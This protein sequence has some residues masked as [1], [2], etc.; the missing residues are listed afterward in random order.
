MHGSATWYHTNNHLNS[1]TIF[2]NTVPVFRRNEWTGSLG[3]P[4]IKNKTFGFFS[5]DI[6]RA[7]VA[8]SST[9][10]DVTPE[11]LNALK[12]LRP[13]AIS[14]GLLTKYPASITPVSNFQT[15]GAL[16][17]PTV[18]CAT[19]AGGPSRTVTTPIG[20][21]PCNMNVI[22]EANFTITPPRKG[23]QYNARLDHVFTAND[24]FF[25]S[26]F[27]NDLSTVGSSVRA[28]FRSPTDQ[29]TENVNLNWTHTFS[30]TL[31]NEAAF[32]VVRAFGDG[33]CLECQIPT[34]SVTNLAGFGNGGPTIFAQNNYEW[35][36]TLTWSRKNHTF[37][38]GLNVYKAQSNFNPTK[39]YQR[40]NFTFNSTTAIFDFA[41]DDPNQ[42]GNIGFNPVDGSP[43][44]PNVAE[45]QQYLTAFVQDNWKVK[46][47]LSV[48]LGLRW[49]EFGRVKEPTGLTNVVFQSGNDFTSR[50]ADGKN[51]LVDHIFNGDW[52][53]FGPRVS[54]AWDPTKTGRMSIRGGAGMF[55]DTA[56]SQL[57]GGSHFNPP[58]WAIATANKTTP[59]F[60]PL[61]GLGKSATDPYQFPRPSNIKTGLDSR[62]GLVSGLVGVT[63]VD[64]N[65][66]NSYVEN[67]F[68]GIQYS[69]AENWVVEGNYVGSG[70][71]KLYA[72]FDV[73]R[74]NGDLLDGVTNRLNPSFGSINYAH[75]PFTSNYE[76]G[77]L[78]L[79]KRFSRGLS[80]EAAYTFGKAL[81]YVS[82]FTA[83]TPTDESNWSNR[84]GPADFDVARKLAL[85][86]AW[87]SPA[88]AAHKY[89][90]NVAG[91]WQV[92]I[93][94]ILQSGAPLTVTCS[95]SFQP[96][97]DSTGKIVGNTGCDFNADGNTSDVP[98]APVS[99]NL[100]SLSRS[101]YQTGLFKT[102]DFP[103]P[104]FG[105][106]G[107]LGKGTYRGPGYAN[108]DLSLM[109]NFKM[110]WY[111]DQG[112]E[113]RFVAEAYNLF[114]RVNLND[115][116][117]NLNT[118]ATFGRST[119]ARAARSVQFGLR[120]SF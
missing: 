42:E 27:R 101:N 3:A 100:G 55:Y 106:E 81:D 105:V 102:T 70:G 13:N 57:Y 38:T 67:W 8:T 6:L 72:K 89:L 90:R 111:T 113:L 50:I 40:P 85:N 32:S 114:N 26:M 77:N 65:M 119:A 80:F 118:T 9:Q 91:S 116:V 112:S 93:V 64:P 7:G 37:K 103:R 97:R 63:W 69:L 17:S 87:H 35:R 76:G 92:G 20:S 79:K 45:R 34:I 1:R 29:Y 83:G 54:V 31:L 11:F 82:G 22:G 47:N 117:T 30:P 110:P 75:A 120:F 51:A 39:G 5:I 21:L 94:T 61:F 36:D 95:T 104:A 19:L 16:I 56:A 49:E 62:N 52:N 108:T 74:F 25:G 115:P 43:N 23:L 60:I 78:S 46:P 28:A 66:R 59:P 48:N 10:R 98:D 58:L 12:T 71:R 84:Y 14:T 44:V 4:I 24:R 53:N 18:N 109:K 99:L 86:L 96:V 41:N 73:N 33:E 68:F 107:N 88:L 2:T 15:V